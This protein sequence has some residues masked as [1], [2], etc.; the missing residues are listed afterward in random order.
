MRVAIATQ[1]LARIDAHFGWA[2]HLMLYEVSAEG[3][4][5]LET[6]SFASARAD[7]DHGKLGPRLEAMEG[8]DLV[9]VAQLGP[10]AELGLSRTRV[11]P[12][13]RFAGQPIALALEA[14]RDGL[15]SGAPVWLR[16]IEQR[17]RREG[18]IQAGS[19]GV[20]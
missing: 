14:L 2:R 17:R 9:F 7:G 8:C 3:C 16:R 10:E 5:Y 13:R 20:D 1:D 19:D 11:T 18:D 6:L 12:I 15:R 4:R